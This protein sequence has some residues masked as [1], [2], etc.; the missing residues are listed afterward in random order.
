[1]HRKRNLW[2]WL[3]LVLVVS[4]ALVIAGCGDDT[5]TTSSSAAT[6][7]TTAATESTEESTESGGDQVE[8]TL[9]HAWA[10][11]H[12]VHV[13]LQKW[14]DE[15]YEA[16]D[17]RVK[18]T[19]YSGGALA[20]PVELYDAL[21]TG[22]ADM[23][24]FLQGYTP[25]KFPLTSV[26]ELPFMAETATIGALTSWELYETYP[27]YREE[28]SDDGVRLLATWC[29]DPGQ[30]LTTKTKV[31]KLEELKNLKI[32]VGSATL[33]PTA[34]ALG[35]VPIL[36]PINELYD[37]LQKGVFDGVLVGAS[38]IKTFNLQDVIKYV[39]INNSFIN[40]HSLGINDAAWNKISKEDQDIILGLSGAKLSKQIGDAFGLEMEAGMKLAEDAG[41]EFIELDEAELARWKEAVSGIY[42]QWIADMDSK[43][44]DGQDLLN[45]ARE[46]V[47]KYS[48]QQ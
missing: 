22:V 10:T 11:T 9:A 42:D 30:L 2:L 16:T 39:T 17:G 40:T 41:A 27:G 45:K 18:I 36:S 1:M 48:S 47:E 43:G 38:A 25:G 32:R 37:S 7:E 6:G 8:L 21:A 20:G 4:F 46:L 35:C 14:A 12:L 31:T 3:G 13:E 44:Y 33:S 5:A 28:Y 29:V 19:I 23:A 24:W 15:V 26:I 34:E